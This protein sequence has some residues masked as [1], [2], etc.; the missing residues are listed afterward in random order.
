MLVEGSFSLNNL[1]LIKYIHKLAEH[2][3]FLLFL[4]RFQRTAYGFDAK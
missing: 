4:T 2:F 3:N 1:N